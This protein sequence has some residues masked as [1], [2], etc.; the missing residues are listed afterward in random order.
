[1][2]RQTKL[3]I[4]LLGFLTLW[5]VQAQSAT[6]LERGRQYANWFYATELE[7]LFA[8]FAPE[9][10]KAV[11]LT[12]LREG[13]ADIE[14]T[15]GRELKVLEE[16]SISDR[17][18]EVY[19]RTSSFEKAPEPLKTTIS[20]E[21]NG[22]IVGFLI[23]P[24]KQPASSNFLEY[25]TKTSFRLPFHDTW[26]VGWGGRTLEQNYHAAYPD[27]RFAYDLLIK[28]DGQTHSGDGKRNEDYFA[29]SQPILAPADA[30][31][32]SSIN[33][34]PDNIPGA[35]NPAQPAGNQVWLDFGNGEFALLAHFKQGSVLV[36]AGQQVK[37]GERLGLCGNSGNSSEAHLH[38][39]LQTTPDFGKGEGLPAQFVNYSADDKPVVRGEPIQSQFIRNR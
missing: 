7:T 39:H 15:F 9:M 33:G 38:F 13:R 6:T 35:M 8:K 19:I 23:E 31:V 3:L 17:G 22:L 27:Q 24:E 34:V 11:P 10:Q 14:K 37:A 20:W 30:R 28:R 21:A 4:F 25:Q 26:F 36:K 2:L 5:T 12:A 29:F 1:M 18:L 16:K 32:V